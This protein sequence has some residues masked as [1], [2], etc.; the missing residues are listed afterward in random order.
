MVPDE[1]MQYSGI[2]QLLQH[3]GWTWVG[4]FIV[5]DNSG[6]QFVHALESLFSQAGICSAFT[7]RIPQQGHADDLIE[8][9]DIIRSIYVCFTN[10]ST[11]VFI[12]Y[13]ESLSFTLLRTMMFLKDPVDRKTSFGKVWITTAQ[14]DFISSGLQRNWDFWMF[15]GAIS[16]TVHSKELPGFKDYLQSIKPNWNQ[17]DHFLKD[18]WEQVFDCFLPDP[19]VP[20]KD[21]EICTGQERLENLP[22][23]LFTMHMTGHSYSI[24]NAVYALTHALHAMHSLYPKHRTIRK[25]N[26][27]QLQYLQP[28][29]LHHFLDGILFNNSAKETLSFGGKRQIVGG[30]D[31]V[32]MVISPNNSFQLVKIGRVDPNAPKRK[33]LVMNESMIVWHSH[34]TQVPPASLCNECCH[35]GNQKKKKEGEKFCCY[36]CVLC[37]EGKIANQT[38]M[39][40]CFQC[41]EDRYPNRNRNHCIPKAINFLSYEEPLGITLASLAVSYSLIIVLVL[42]IFLMHNNT[43]IVR[44]NNQELTYML[45]FLLLLCFL[46]SLLFLR[47]PGKVNCLLRQPTFAIVFSMAISCVLAKT[48]LVSLAFRATKPGSR[49]KNWVGKGLSHSIAFSCSLIQLFICTMW[50]TS[51]PP[52]PDLDMHSVTEEIN[53]QCNEG[54]VTMFYCVLGYMGLLALSSFVVAFLARKL[55]DSFNESK[56]VTFSMLV[57]CSVWLSFVPTYL[58]TRGKAMVAVEIFAI[59]FSGAGLLFCIFCPKCYIIVWRPDLNCREQLIKRKH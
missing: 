52:F 51:T 20:I 39:A 12:F 2:V 18:T 43:P 21:H 36:T 34:F 17:G 41:P 32:N 3:F 22:A 6:E 33:A 46:S 29:Q 13:G 14:I 7:E 38:D 28:W 35:P 56:F 59:L 49:L 47:Q 15:E 42:G 1:S 5:D 54:S 45:L 50:L 58:S 19:R 10:Y 8:M 53:F 40:N 55:P 11:N 31:I 37:P 26:T 44:A 23:G 57:F 4:L 24:Y 30:F 16:F 9:N 25:G 48:T 27:V